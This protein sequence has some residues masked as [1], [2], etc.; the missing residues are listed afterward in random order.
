MFEFSS[1]TGTGSGNLPLASCA[2][3]VEV[4]EEQDRESLGLDSC[5]GLLGYDSLFLTRL[6]VTPH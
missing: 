1:A 5:C 2:R 3:A 4:S 6:F